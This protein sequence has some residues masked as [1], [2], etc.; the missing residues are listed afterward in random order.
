MAVIRLGTSGWSYKEW[1]NVFYPRDAKDKLTFYS[2]IFKTVEIDST[3]YEYPKKAMIQ[4]CARVTPDDFVFSARVPKLITHDKRLDVQKGVGEDL[5][6]FIYDLRPLEDAGKLGPLLLQLPPSFS[7]KDGL[8][9]L[10][11]F[12]GALPA[13]LKFAVEFRNKSWHRPETWDLLRQ[14]KIAN[15][16]ADDP[17]LPADA[18]VTADFAVIRWYGRGKKPWGDYRYSD[19]EIDGWAPRVKEVEARAKEVYGYFG[20]HFRGNAV[21]NTLRIMDK[22]GLADAE[23]K[24]LGA[25]VTRAI[26]LKGMRYTKTKGPAPEPVV[27]K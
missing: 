13:D 2:G 9:R 22:L 20:N 23:G 24:E 4:A 5:M 27:K 11:D 15:T 6:R 10:I 14:C 18:T 3:F 21:E 7:Y 16:I 12:F 25:R 26:Q 8:G 17:L 1:E 19:A